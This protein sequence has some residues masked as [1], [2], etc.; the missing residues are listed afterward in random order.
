MFLNH[1]IF[2][3]AYLFLIKYYKFTNQE[4]KGMKIFFAHE[5]FNSYER[6]H[7]FSFLGKFNSNERL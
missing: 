6:H 7:K 1:C 2:I 5:E 4:R 3:F